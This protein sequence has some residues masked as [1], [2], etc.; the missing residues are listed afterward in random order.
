[1]AL[2]NAGILRPLTQT[3]K[4]AGPL[5]PAFGDLVATNRGLRPISLEG[6]SEDV[7][8]DGFVDPVAQ[9]TVPVVAP[10]AAPIAAPV[11]YSNPA[12]IPAPILKAAEPVKVEVKAPEPIKIEA[13]AIQTIAYNAPIAPIAPIATAPIQTIAYSAP[14]VQT[15]AY[16]AAPV[17][18]GPRI[19]Q[20]ALLSPFPLASAAPLVNAPLLAGSPIL[21]PV[22]EK[23]E[24]EV[25]A[26]VEE[27]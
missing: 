12:I 1:M 21:A 7:N 9:A 13:P 19:A 5:T 27:A 17:I 25:D 15:M 3:G 18:T 2:A 4:V 20:Q 26:V 23:V 6:F 11:V 10:V 22:A 24:A 14:A 16:N 8:A